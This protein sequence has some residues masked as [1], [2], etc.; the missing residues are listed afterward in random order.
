MREL[1]IEGEPLEVRCMTVHAA[2][3]ALIAGKADFRDSRLRNQVDIHGLSSRRTSL[4]FGRFAARRVV[5]LKG[6]Q[7]E[8]SDT[9]VLLPVDCPAEAAQRCHGCIM[10]VE[11]GPELARG[12]RAVTD[13]PTTLL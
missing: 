3:G 8:T 10:D 2:L 9:E 6:I 12:I 13:I 7:P 11:G 4:R 1:Y 5:T